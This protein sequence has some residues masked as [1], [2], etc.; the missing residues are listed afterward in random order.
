VIALPPSISQADT[1][2]ACESVRAGEPLTQLVVSVDD[3]ELLMVHV[4]EDAVLY[5]I[6][7]DLGCLMNEPSTD[8]WG[9]FPFLTHLFR[10]SEFFHVKVRKVVACQ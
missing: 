7:Y 2:P 10:L 1:H 5:D 8:A 3:V 9:T 6:T 4:A